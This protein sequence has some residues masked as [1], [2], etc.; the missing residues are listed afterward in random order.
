VLSLVPAAFAVND[1]MPALA[2][3]ESRLVDREGGRPT[4]C[5]TVQAAIPTVNVVSPHGDAPTEELVLPGTMQ[6]FI[7][8]ISIPRNN[9]SKLCAA[10]PPPRGAG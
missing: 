10:P 7:V 6:A 1:S 8:V 5:A 2:P 4:T 9:R 3:E